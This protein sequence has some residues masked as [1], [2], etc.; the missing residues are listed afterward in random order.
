MNPV[1]ALDEDYLRRT[2]RV[3]RL[4]APEGGILGGVVRVSGDDVSPDF[5]M[6]NA[7]LG[8]LTPVFPH[9]RAADGADASGESLGGS[10]ADTDLELAWLRA[11]MEGA[12]RYATMAYSL[13]EF[14]VASANELGTAALDLDTIPRCSDAELAD[15]KCPFVRADKGK[16]IRWARAHSLVDRRERLVPAVMTHLYFRPM[17]EE[18]FWQM[19]STGVAAH[20]TLEAALVSAICE[21]IERDAIALTWLA[22]LPLPRITLPATPPAELATNLNRQARSLVAH[23]GFDATTDVGVPTIYAVQTLDGHP[24]LAQY[25]NCAT[26][27]DA[28]RAYA[29]TIRE[30]APARTVFEDGLA[31]PAAVADFE[32]LHD[33]AAY[34]GKPE[35]RAAFSFLLDSAGQRPLA[36]IGQ[37]APSDDAGRLA[38]LI[39]RLKAMGMDILALDLTTRDLRALGVWVVRVVIPG[40]MPMTSTHRGRFLGH[41]RLYEY[42]RAAGFGALSEADI[43]PAP[44]PFA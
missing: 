13:D 8:N 24:H 11:V 17:P 18:N 36:R 7:N 41:P 3:A 30:A 34:L 6:A 23:H 25:V 16:P 15:P 19:I 38:W 32:S 27:F 39:A 42:P 44:Q 28:A 35:H 43:N 1:I 37:P 5:H 12:E 31:H 4:L 20:V 33:G 21:V 9:V 40:L 29:K 14:I 26:D 22:R 10:G 2:Y